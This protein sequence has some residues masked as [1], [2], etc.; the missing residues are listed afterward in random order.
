MVDPKHDSIDRG[1]VIPGRTSGRSA[2]PD[3]L[4]WSRVGLG[5]LFLIL[6]L[7]VRRYP[8]VL[9]VPL[10]CLGWLTDSLDG[11]LARALRKGSSSWVGRRDYIVDAFFAACLLIYL[12]SLRYISGPFGA[13][14]GVVAL[15]AMLLRSRVLNMTFIALVYFTFILISFQRST[16]LGGILVVTALVILALDWNRFK[17]LVRLY[18]RGA[19]DLVRGKHD[20]GV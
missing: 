13:A 4:T 1:P 19:G 14:F 18:L 16:L 7:V 2:I 17:D 15:F 8:F 9:L 12:L 10:V 5:V 3:V 6:A 11:T 20:G